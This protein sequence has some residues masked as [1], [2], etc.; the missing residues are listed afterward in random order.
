MSWG[1]FRYNK[2]A[3]RPGFLHR[4]NR[5]D[6]SGRTVK[7]REDHS[8]PAAQ[9]E[10]LSEIFGLASVHH[11]LKVCMRIQRMKYRHWQEALPFEKSFS[12]KK[13]MGRNYHHLTPRCRR[14]GPHHGEG[15]RNLLLMRI[16][17]HVAWHKLFGIRTLEEV[18]HALKL[19]SKLD[20]EMWVIFQYF[21]RY[22]HDR[23]PMRRSLRNFQHQLLAAA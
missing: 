5:K 12:K 13:G 3:S 17:R 21:S 14:T 8:T 2:K 6:R 20:F 4:R 19:C 16:N 23:Q 10:S 15:W 22:P 18:I 11:A 7:V 9:E 1:A